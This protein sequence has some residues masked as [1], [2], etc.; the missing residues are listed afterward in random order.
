MG[1]AWLQE[2]LD[3]PAG[4]DLLALVAQIEC[5]V[6]AIHGADDPTVPASS[7]QRIGDAAP[8]GSATLIPGANHVFNTP[9]PLPD[10]AD[11]SAEL[12]A[13]LDAML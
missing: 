12:K 1:K 2:Q 11:P 9:N 10:D 7:A 6:I 5:P 13:M 8:H 4:H 3:D